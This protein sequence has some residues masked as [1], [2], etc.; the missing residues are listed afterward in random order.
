MIPVI[1]PAYEPDS[2]FPVL[3]GTLAENN[4]GPVIV[5]DDGSG[6]QY[7]A[8]FEKAGSLVEGN[9]GTVLVHEVNRGKG[10]ALK[11]AFQYILENYQ[12]V[13][14]AVTADSDGQHTVD[15][16][17]KVMAALEE[18]PQELIL[19]VRDFSGDDIPWKSR[20]GNNLAEK[21]FAYVAGV[22]V[23]D[24]QTGLRGIPR[25]FMRDLLEVA[26]ER[27]EFETQMLLESVNRYPISEVE[28]ETIYDSVDDHQTH[29]DP[30]ADSIKIYRILGKKF[31][32]Y[33]FASFSSSIL[34]L[35]LFSV[36][37]FFLE[38]R[39]VS[40]VAVATVLARIIST[41]YNYTI[42]YK[43][44]FKSKENVGK[45]SAKYFLLAVI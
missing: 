34:D 7:A 20:F 44:V 39:Y 12:G 15:C 23:S 40:Y 14:G 5:V 26:G 41:V 18:K 42:N 25:E 4:V 21:V 13:I 45:A 32:K 33:I 38:G 43:V 19:G 8:I 24:T 10:R 9:S 11:T 27:F 1:I 3:L 35:A 2:N 28:I 30:V 6:E 31:L 37:C 36:F 29:F 22:H 16:I 17:R